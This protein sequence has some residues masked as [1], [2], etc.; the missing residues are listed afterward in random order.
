MTD[1]SP[2]CFGAV[3][4]HSASSSKCK[5]CPFYSDCQVKV[6]TTISELSGLLG[7]EEVM[8][9]HKAY[10]K[11]AA[12]EVKDSGK[13]R[14]F[15]A[16]K[17]RDITL[18]TATIQ[19]TGA[20]EIAAN[21]MRCV[22]KSFVGGKSATEIVE[23]IQSG[24][25]PYPKEQKEQWILAELLKTGPVS[26]STVHATIEKTGGSATRKA[27]AIRALIAAKL[28]KQEGDKITLLK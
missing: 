20:V 28:I 24:S 1:T 21:E 19:P 13:L 3:T 17:L 8:R 14:S 26:V 16:P 7:V 6:Q 9:K 27:V 25:N 12:A 11:P 10:A 22:I 5:A 15:A 4:R 23:A 18:G 2:L